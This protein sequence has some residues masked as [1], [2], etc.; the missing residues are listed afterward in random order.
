MLVK[1]AHE[2]FL[3]LLIRMYKRIIN[4][5]IIEEADAHSVSLMDIIRRPGH[6]I[7]LAQNAEEAKELLDTR[8]FVLIFLDLDMPGKK[9]DEL[10]KRVKAQVRTMEEKA[11]HVALILT[12]NQKE[13]VYEAIRQNQEEIT[14]DYLIRPYDKDLVKIKV[15]V[16]RQL[17]FKH[18]R[19]SQL[20]ES[21]L[22]AQTLKEF[23]VYGKSSPRKKENCCIL[24]T[25]FVNFSAKTRDKDPQEIVSVLDTYFTQFDSIILKYK[26]E[27]IKTIG[28]AYMAVGGVTEKEPHPAIRTALAALEIRNFI[29]TNK[30]TRKAFGKD[31]WE[32][33]VGAHIGDLVAGVVGQHKFSFDVWGHD[34]NIAARCEQHSAANKISISKA[35]ATAI[36][37][38]F[39]VIPRG[40]IT[41]KNNDAVEMFFLEALKPPF[42]L[43]GEG[44]TANIMIRQEVGLPGADFNGIRRYILTRLKAELDDRLIYHS[45]EHSEKVEQAVMKYAAL[46]NLSE[47]ETILLRTAAL[48]HD[49]GFLFRYVDNE[50]LGVEL[51]HSIAPD[52]GYDDDSIKK[53]SEII[54]S[55]AYDQQPKNILEAI[56]CDADLDYLGR[57]DYHSTAENLFQEESDYGHSF[58]PKE[59]LKKQIQ[60]LSNHEY[61]TVSAQNLRGPGKNK[62]LLEVRK[63][64]E[65]L[66]GDSHN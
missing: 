40:K 37:P 58:T 55:T 50:K 21:I 36:A 61:Y 53:V 57:L 18:Q 26:L 7:F 19:I 42:S 9:M 62:R 2:K 52:F 32:V 8:Q 6:N 15:N 46:E 33:R 12:S 27:K 16:F 41:L 22:P 20:L 10:L 29:L 35:M 1:R 14:L 11:G 63:K 31:F 64:L 47:E 60:Y 65:E 43:H 24:F 51:F 45:Y 44:R 48:F 17:Y 56:M 23:Q 54:L 66:T 3:Y 13:V 59:I 38:Y 34:V 28:D 25:D 39:E 30:E 5:L 49:A 4:I